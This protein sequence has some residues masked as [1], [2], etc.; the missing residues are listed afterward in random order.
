MLNS[1]SQAVAAQGSQRENMEFERSRPTVVAAMSPFIYA[2]LGTVSASAASSGESLKPPWPSPMF[3]A[4]VRMGLRDRAGSPGPILSEFYSKLWAPHKMTGIELPD[5]ADIQAC[6][7]LLASSPSGLPSGPSS[8]M[9]MVAKNADWLTASL[10]LCYERLWEPQPGASS[11]SSSPQRRTSPDLLRPDLREAGSSLNKAMKLFAH[12]QQRERREHMRAQLRPT[13]KVPLPPDVPPEAMS[14]EERL[15]E[16]LGQPATSEGNRAPDF[17]TGLLDADPS[18]VQ[19]A[20][21]KD[22][23]AGSPEQ[24]TSDRPAQPGDG[25]QPEP[26]SA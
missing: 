25:V 7:E 24:E 12:A 16:A 20:N 1:L 21:A 15:E 23:E 11:S 18:T 9:P 6:N 3:S 14:L 4:S 22:I 17:K 2:D 5:I 26:P 10:L 19:L 13:P 8:H